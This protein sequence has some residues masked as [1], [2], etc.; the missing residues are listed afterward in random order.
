MR[1]NA[2]MCLKKKRLPWL[3]DRR[4]KSPKMHLE[5]KEIS[6]LYVDGDED[7]EPL[8]IYRVMHASSDPLIEVWQRSSVF[9]KGC[10]A[11]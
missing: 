2:F 1:H 9:R 5:N 4:E 7:G 6:K 3:N 11:I 10:Y 8:L